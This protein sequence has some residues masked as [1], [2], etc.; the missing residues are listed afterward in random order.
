[1]HAAARDGGPRD[2]PTR[3]A[4]FDLAAQQALTLAALGDRDNAR[5]V[6]RVLGRLSPD[7]PLLAEL[8]ARLAQTRR[9]RVE[10]ADL[11]D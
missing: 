4:L 9:G 8:S 6:M 7:D 1:V 2:L 10:V 11:I 3:R 5:S